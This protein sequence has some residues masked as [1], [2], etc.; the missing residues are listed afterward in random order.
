MPSSGLTSNEVEAR[1]REGLANAVAK[2]SHRTYGEILRANIFTLFNAILAAL[3]VVILLFGSIA[4]ALFG[5]ILVLNALIGIVQEIR[6]KWTLEAL[7]VLNAPKAR[8]LRDGHVSEIP[9]EE[10]VIDDI[11]ELRLGDQLAVDGTVVASDGLE[12]DESLLSG[13]SLP[14]GKNAGD[15]A[16]SGSFV[17]AG[18]GR[19]KVTQVGAKTYVQTLTAEARTFALSRSELMAGIDAFLRYV[20]WAL[21]IVAPF[22]FFT[23]VH[24]LG[25][26]SGAVPRT[27]AGL[28]GMVPQGLVLLTTIAFAVSVILLGRRKALVQELPAVESLA[29]A[30]VVCFDKTGTLTKNEVSFHSIERL[31][32]TSLLEDVLRAFGAVSSGS[33]TTAA[34]AAA[35]PS[36]QS[37]RA[38]T[39][40]PFSSERK[41]SAIQMDDSAIWLLG[42]P[43]ILLRRSSRSTDALLRAAAW[44]QSGY[45]VLLLGRSAKAVTPERPPEDVSGAALLLFEEEIRPDTPATLAFFERQGVALKVISG[46]NPKTIA[47]VCARAGLTDIGEVVD[48]D[49]GLP[50]EL[51]ELGEIMEKHGVFGRIK[52]QQ[53]RDMIKA[54]QARGHI[55]AMVGDGVNDVL[56]LKE[57]V[58][59]VAMGNGAAATKAVAQVVLLD[60]AFST[61]PLIMAEG[62]KVAANIERVANIFLTK[63]IYISFLSIGVALLAL[64]FPFLPRHLTL[65]NAVTIGIPSFFLALAPAAQRYR[66]GFVRRVLQFVVPV[67]LMAAAAAVTTY[68]LVAMQTS[69]TTAQATSV[70][71]LTILVFGFWV[72]I[73]VS[74]PLVL[75]RGAL[76]GAMA[77]LSAAVLMVPLTRSFFALAIPD[78]A[79]LAETA[80]ITA[81][82]LAILAIV[83]RGTA[84]KRGAPQ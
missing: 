31:E 48:A 64:P 3:L 67:G 10:I 60:S 77:M 82:Y 61:L 4:D 55:V 33:S 24:F 39:I 25:S 6:A 75:W 30:D 68:A 13:E 37:R 83:L 28:V 19:F 50:A 84:K 1:R 58:L 63:T 72:L 49:A 20:V 15:V 11:L 34:L 71:F 76:L 45:R 57:A 81:V 78:G 54:L 52:P 9:I 47:A 27:V 40:V 70:A 32:K 26:V 66:A 29:R 74:R 12:I 23:Q 18:S 41:W 73:R 43:E 38:R 7:V 59:G 79:I 65:I 44:T 16:Y 8:A 35:F 14:I 17:V 42:A 56:A 21:I 51:G 62:R 69:A 53:K 22:L 46:D 36:H 5:I 2:V 80:I